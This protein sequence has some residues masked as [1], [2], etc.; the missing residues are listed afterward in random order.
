MQR[1]P[2]KCFSNTRI[3]TIQI[4][5]VYERRYGRIFELGKWVRAYS[6]TDIRWP[7]LLLRTARAQVWYLPPTNKQGWT[8]LPI[9]RTKKNKAYVSVPPA[10]YRLPG[11][12]NRNRRRSDGKSSTSALL[13][14]AT[15][16]KKDPSV[17]C[18]QHFFSDFVWWSVNSGFWPRYLCECAWYNHH[19]RQLCKSFS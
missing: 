9:M 13:Q 12:G 6:P 10:P 16:S 15:E 5:D 11:Q 3:E 8:T 18:L 19:G 14:A 17:S 7:T 4:V 1:R 2:F